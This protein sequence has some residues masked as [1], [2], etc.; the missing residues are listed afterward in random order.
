LDTVNAQIAA[1]NQRLK[2][3]P[4]NEQDTV[5]LARDAMVAQEIYTTLLNNVEQLRVL[6]AGKTGNVRLLDGAE[7]ITVPVWPR[8]GLIILVATTLGIFVGLVTAFAF[9][10]LR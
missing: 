1:F 9:K 3:I 2:A 5:G 7:L 8:P 10:A 6:K 4:A